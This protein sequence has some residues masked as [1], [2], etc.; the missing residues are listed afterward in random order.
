MRKPAQHTAITG[1][2]GGRAPASV[3]TRGAPDALV[4]AVC[5]AVFLAL[6]TALAI[7]PH[8]R[9][10]W[11]LENLPTFVGVPLAIATYRRFRF[12]DRAYVQATVFLV[13]HTIG[14]HYTYSEV[15]FGDWLRDLLHLTRNHYDRIVHFAFGLLMLRPVRELGLREARGPFAVL[16]FSVAGVA[17]WSVVYEIVEWLVAAV[18]D[19]AAGTAYLGTQGDVWDAEKDMGLALCGA[20]LAA[21]VEWRVDR[22]PARRA[23]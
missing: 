9:D 8:Y 23:P 19:P 21:A 2:L 5:L 14:S 4:P 18:A 22:P 17:C 15:P 20:L 11:V 1:A 12:S 10:D 13:L 16:Y 7:A 6:W 3:P